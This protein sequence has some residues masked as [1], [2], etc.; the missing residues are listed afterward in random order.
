MRLISFLPK[1]AR[2]LSSANRSCLEQFLG[3]YTKFEFFL[4]V[5]FGSED[6]SSFLVVA[7]AEAVAAAAPFIDTFQTATCLLASIPPSQCT[8]RYAAAFFLRTRLSRCL[9]LE[10]PL[11]EKEQEEEAK[12][13]ISINIFNS[14]LNNRLQESEPSNHGMRNEF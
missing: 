13:Q 2:L 1:P 7:V 8:R 12:K 3:Y 14:F 11:L 10:A 4:A 5:F 9:C 6:S